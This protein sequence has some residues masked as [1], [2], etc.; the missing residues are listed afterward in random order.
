MAIYVL[1]NLNVPRKPCILHF[2]YTKVHL[3]NHG[4]FEMWNWSFFQYFGF[5]YNICAKKKVQRAKVS[6]IK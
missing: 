6:G 2:T 1:Q 3:T 5:I 4:T